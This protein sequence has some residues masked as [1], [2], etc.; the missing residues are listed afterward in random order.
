MALAKV[1]SMIFFAAFL[2]LV[3]SATNFLAFK[4]LYGLSG[5]GMPLY[6]VEA[7]HYTPLDLSVL[8]FYA[9][10]VLFKLGGLVVIGLWLA[11]LSVLFKRVLYPYLLGVML[12]VGGLF[13]SGYLASVETGTTRWALGS[14][15]TLLKGNELFSGLLGLNIGNAFFLRAWVC[16]VV[17]LIIAMGLYLLIRRFS[18]LRSLMKSKPLLMKAGG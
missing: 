10:L 7:Y 1:L 6:G 2:L 8:G 4:F 16:L 18:T 14:P 17:Q 15:F 3:F 11:L 5:E 13:A 9:L 12:N